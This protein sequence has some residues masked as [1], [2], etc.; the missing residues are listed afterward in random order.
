MIE[1]GWFRSHSGLQLPWKVNADT[2]SDDD[3]MGIAQII[4]WKFAFSTV[5]GVPRGGLRL[6]EALKP[7]TEP[8]Y[9]E[10]IVDDVLTT[11][12]SMEAYRLA[13]P[14]AIGVVVFARAP[15]PNWVWPIFQ[16]NEWAQSR[17][18]GLG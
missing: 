10:L 18:T 12:K 6:A 3:I 1:F 9:P 2:L 5:I 15:V 17:A 13:A 4:R 7:Y 8:Y 14:T 11:G 16:V